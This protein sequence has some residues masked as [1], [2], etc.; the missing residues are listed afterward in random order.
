MICVNRNWKIQLNQFRGTIKNRSDPDELK[1]LKNKNME[2]EKFD[3]LQNDLSVWKVNTIGVVILSTSMTAQ[4]IN[5][6][7]PV[8]LFSQNSALFL[9][10]G[11]R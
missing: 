5:L 3:L 1:K 10:K 11:F 8:P 6:Y 2:R 7:L 9:K 4:Q